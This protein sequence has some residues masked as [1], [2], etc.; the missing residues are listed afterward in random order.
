MP[1]TYHRARRTHL[2][3]PGLFLLALILGACDPAPTPPP[4]T[5]AYGNVIGPVH[6]PQA[7]AGQSLL[8]VRLNMEAPQ[9]EAALVGRGFTLIYRTEAQAEAERDSPVRL[10]RFWISRA[11]GTD[12][13]RHPEYV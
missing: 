2:A 6:A 3:A 12:A 5:D 1:R 13:Y 11:P 9:A 10:R 4:A 7:L 8:G